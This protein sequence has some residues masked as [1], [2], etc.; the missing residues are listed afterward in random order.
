MLDAI[1]AAESRVE[2]LQ[3]R[4]SDPEI[5]QGDAEQVSALRGALAE[6]EAEVARL[7]AR[8]EELE[9]IDS[10]AA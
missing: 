9:A 3:V 5:Y 4:L 2:T 8:W 6:A 7:T 1:E 10:G